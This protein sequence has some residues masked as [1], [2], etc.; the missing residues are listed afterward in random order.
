MNKF[1]LEQLKNTK[2]KLPYYDDNTV[3]LFIPKRNDIINDENI[4]GINYKILLEDYIIH[5]YDGF[6]LHENWNNNVIP[7]D[8]IMNVEIIQ[9]LGKMIKISGIGVND[10]KVWSGWVPKSSIKIIERL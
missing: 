6:T 8:N 5:P 7:T 3:E 10:N 9:Q 4:V 1:I 2:V